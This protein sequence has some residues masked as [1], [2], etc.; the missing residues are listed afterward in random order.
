MKMQIIA[1]IVICFL[2]SGVTQAESLQI[3]CVPPA[4]TFKLV[5]SG[6]FFLDID[7]G[8]NKFTGHVSNWTACV[9]KGNDALFGCYTDNVDY[10]VVGLVNRETNEFSIQMPELNRFSTV[11]IKLSSKNSNEERLSYTQLNKSRGY[12][13][14]CSQVKN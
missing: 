5:A 13:L 6:N 3:R 11:E 10:H 14:Y 8:T 4:G 12:Y 1:S 9:R 2:L 7:S